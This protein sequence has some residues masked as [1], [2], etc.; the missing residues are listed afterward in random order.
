MKALI[1]IL[2]ATAGVLGVRALGFRSCCDGGCPTAD[3]APSGRYVEARTA[4]VY[5]GACH[6]GSELVTGGREAVLCWS[7]EGGSVDGAPLAG[8]ELVAA[9]ASSANL[10][11]PG[12]H[13]SVIYVGSKASEAAREAAV[14]W[15]RATQRDVLGEVV[16]VETAE[17]E[18]RIEAERYTARV[19][20]AIALEGSAM[21]DRECCTMPFNVW[22]EPC[23]PLEGRLV[24]NSSRFEWREKR[25][26][27]PFERREQNDAFLGGFGAGHGAACRS[28][29]SCAGV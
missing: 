18:L 11:Q 13:R 23:Q 24:G 29:S 8:V 9:V 27:P 1:T 10:T 26:A 4:S 19:G 2:A 20:S 22:Y 6:Y 25:L 5:A 21:P 7:F 3:V 12:A 16:A 28:G 15:L 17:V 14:E